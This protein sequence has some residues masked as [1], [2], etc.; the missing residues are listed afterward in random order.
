M[1]IGHT[2]EQPHVAQAR[3]LSGRLKVNSAQMIKAAIVLAGVF[4]FEMM[5][6]RNK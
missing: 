4:V 5:F 1:A 6:G 2:S 3:T